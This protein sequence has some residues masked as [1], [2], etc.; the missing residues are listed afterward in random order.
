MALGF[1][2]T[3]RV[4]LHAAGVALASGPLTGCAGL[5]GSTDST[6]TVTMTPAPIPPQQV[7]A[8]PDGFDPWRVRAPPGATIDWTW[9]TDGHNIVVMA[10]PDASDWE[11]HEA[12][13]HTGFTYRHTFTVEGTYDYYCE[14]HVREPDHSSHGQVI[15]TSETPTSTQSAVT[16]ARGRSKVTV[17]IGP[18]GDLRFDP[19]AL[20]ISTGTTVTWVWDTDN[21]NIVVGKQPPEA[22][23]EGH[24]RIEYEGFTYTHT[25]TVAGRYEYWCQ[26]HQDLGREWTI[27]VE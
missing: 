26:P 23:W 27:L 24:E 11:G 5:F 18:D 22:N 17:T 2:P 25:F 20:R 10:K 21:H 6:S 13:E 1:S 14:P 7:V 12:I 16:D 3:R 15:I 8:G 19:A 9:E 4:V